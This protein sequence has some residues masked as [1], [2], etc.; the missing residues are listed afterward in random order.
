[1]GQMHGSLAITMV[2]LHNILNISNSL[3]Y[4]VHTKNTTQMMCQ[5]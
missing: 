3:I 2:A 5:I 1:L 4:L